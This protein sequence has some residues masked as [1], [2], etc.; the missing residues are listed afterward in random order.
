MG[1]PD[2]D[3]LQWVDYPNW[4]GF[5]QALIYSLVDLAISVVK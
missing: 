2:G 1:N 4:Q 5:R 3:Y